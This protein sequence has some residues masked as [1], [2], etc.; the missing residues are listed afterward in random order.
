VMTVTAEI[1]ALCATLLN[2]PYF[3]LVN[4]Q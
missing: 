4:T 3:G 2:L 1:V